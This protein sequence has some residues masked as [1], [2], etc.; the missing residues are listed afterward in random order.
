LFFENKILP[1]FG[2]RGIVVNYF[3][4]KIAWKFI[5][6]QKRL[7]GELRNNNCRDIDLIEEIEF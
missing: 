2:R 5:I 4:R 1:R 3:I 6:D 7:S